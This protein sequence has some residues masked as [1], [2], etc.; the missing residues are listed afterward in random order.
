MPELAEIFVQSLEPE[1]YG[2][3]PLEARVV[4][5]FDTL[6]EDGWTVDDILDGIRQQ[7]LGERAV[8]RTADGRCN[9]FSRSRLNLVARAAFKD[10]EQHGS[11]RRKA[12]L[13]W[14]RKRQYGW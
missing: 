4:H 14:V 3:T 2:R 6:Q 8:V 11:E 7:Q 13:S 1:S 12:W 10:L 9:D 5:A